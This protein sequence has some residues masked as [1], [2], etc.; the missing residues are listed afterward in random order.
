[1]AAGSG[2]F[3]EDMSALAK[4]GA[5]V[6]QYPTQVSLRW[7]EQKFEMDLSLSEAK[8][9][10][11]QTPEVSARRFQMPRNLGTNPINLAEYRFGPK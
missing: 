10:E 7:E 11:P 8:M 6:M 9:N 5:G 2:S 3:G 1:M 4:V